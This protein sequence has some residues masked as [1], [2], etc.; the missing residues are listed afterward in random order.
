VTIDRE[1]KGR[2]M[3]IKERFENDPAFRM[4]VDMFYACIERGDYTPT[5]IREAAMYAQIWWES[6]H[7]RPMQFTVDDVLRGKV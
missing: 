6:T 7:I 5:E 2:D 4:M 3:K 1:W